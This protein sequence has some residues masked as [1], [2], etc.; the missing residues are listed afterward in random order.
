MH[1]ASQIN[2][3]ILPPLIQQL[4]ASPHASLRA[5]V[6]GAAVGLFDFGCPADVNTWHHMAQRREALVA[7]C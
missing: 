5:A 7:L 4:S 2:T 3:P 1:G 6:G